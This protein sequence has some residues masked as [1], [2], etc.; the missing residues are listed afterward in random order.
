MP[1]VKAVVAMQRD[2]G[3]RADRRHARLKYLVDDKGLAWIKATLDEYFGARL[4]PPRPMPRFEMPDHMGWHPQGDGKW[5]L[6]I[7]VSSGRIG[8]RGGERLRGGLRHVVSTYRVD[9]VLT[10]QQD[11]ILSNVAADRRGAIERD[12]R[13]FGV[14]LAEE[15]TPVRRWAMACPALPTCGLALTE[16]ER[17][18]LPLI[19]EVEKLLARYG[20]G[21]ERMTVRITGCPNGCARP[22][23][24]DIGL[25]GRM[26]GIYALYVGGDFEG[27]RL[28]EQLLEKVALDE[29]PAVLEPLFAFFAR[30]RRPG[31]GFGDFC[32]RQGAG[33]LRRRIER[34]RE[35]YA[36][37]V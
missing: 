22:Y 27:T 25:V 14:S 13:R 35:S 18:K 9:P 4:A 3:D 12:L 15:L 23:T 24:G 32:H 34:A 19:E 5:Y 1:A 16:A 37:A 17:V 33:A 31:E 2:H 29:V 11:I 8:D 21:D 6:G 30:A 36:E 26:P 10:P 7:P 28:S 20:L